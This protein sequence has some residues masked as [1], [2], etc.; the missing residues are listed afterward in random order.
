MTQIN[1]QFVYGAGNDDWYGGGLRELRYYMNKKFNGQINSPDIVDYTEY[2][3]LKAR[4][5][6]WKDPTILVGH[7]C[8]DNPITYLPNELTSK[9][10]PFI[11]G[12]APSIYCP[13]SALG[14]NVQRACQ[15]TSWWGDIFN[16][17]GRTLMSWKSGRK[18]DVIA[19]GLGHVAA[20]YSPAV[21][22][23]LENEIQLALEGK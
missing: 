22:V 14:S 19:T 16:P 12:I 8:G 18:M 9:K 2:A 15:A 7:S 6:S 4:V 10:F 20:P 13:V 5:A 3:K 21:R 1:L 17:G 23:R 11:F